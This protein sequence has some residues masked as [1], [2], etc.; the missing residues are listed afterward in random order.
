MEFGLRARDR[1]ILEAVIASYMETGNPV[2]SRALCKRYKLDLSPATVRNVMG[3]LEDIGLLAQPHASA[4]RVPTDRGFR[5]YV[6]T[7][8]Q[9][10]ELTPEE[11]GAIEASCQIS[12][13][14]PSDLMRKTSQILSQITQYTGLVRAP[15]FSDTVIKQIEFIQ[16]GENRI[17]VILVSR[18]GMVHNSIIDVDRHLGQKELDKYTKY[19]NSLLGHLTL[20][21]LKERIVQEME[22][23]KEAFDQL[24]LRALELSRRALTSDPDEGLYIGGKVNI[25]QQREFED[26][27]QMRRLLKAFEDKRVLIR[28][29]EKSA[30]APGIQIF[31]G[32]ENEFAE[33]QDC[34]VIT[35]RFGHSGRLMGTLGVIGPKRMNYSKVVPIVEYT[36]QMVTKALETA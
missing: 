23:E 31:I 13:P 28:I 10:Q 6:D 32:A 5:F 7:I 20:A 33:M 24:F 35:S 12:S 19:V 36:A 30:L 25:F 27:E 21:E 18:S 22:R 8:M 1:E 2:G 4:G 11:R 15:S 14:E 16:L 3:D 9:L 17:L 34:S 29:L 26:I